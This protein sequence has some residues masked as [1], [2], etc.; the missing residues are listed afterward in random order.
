[1]PN[2]KIDLNSILIRREDVPTTDIDGEL[3]M[4]SIEKG[5]YFTLDEVGTRIWGILETP[6]SIKE[7]VDVLIQE[8][9]VDFDTC[10]NDVEE[11]IEK[12]LQEDLIAI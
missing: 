7:I 8:Y 5:K 2:K 10:A 11:L 6:H 4:M 3:G 1:M 9:D 12:L